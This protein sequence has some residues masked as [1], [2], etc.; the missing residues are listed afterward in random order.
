[1]E[2]S[3]ENIAENHRDIMMQL[4]S[5]K[6]WPIKLFFPQNYSKNRIELFPLVSRAKLLQHI[7]VARGSN[8]AQRIGAAITGND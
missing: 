2:W 5:G 4:R 1:M 6:R 8:R 7:K 3:Q